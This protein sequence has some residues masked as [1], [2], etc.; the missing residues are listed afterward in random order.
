MDFYTNYL[1][2]IRDIFALR[3]ELNRQKNVATKL[4]EELFVEIYSRLSLKL[5]TALRPTI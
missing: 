4:R 3:S 1:V 2:I 5:F